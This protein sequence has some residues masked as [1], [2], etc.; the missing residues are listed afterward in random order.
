MAINVY[1][2]ISNLNYYYEKLDAC[3][4]GSNLDILLCKIVI[5]PRKKP[6]E[7][8]KIVNR[9]VNKWMFSLLNFNLNIQ[10]FYEM[11][12]QNHKMIIAAFL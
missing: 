12:F 6:A 5:N 11:H 3:N 2:A 4:K 1:T 10:R 8:L 7:K 9:L